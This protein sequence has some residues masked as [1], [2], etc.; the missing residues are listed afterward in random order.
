MITEENDYLELL[1]EKN[2]ALLM[3]YPQKDF[4][5]RLIQR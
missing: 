5:Q 1:V 4:S 2:N 3:K